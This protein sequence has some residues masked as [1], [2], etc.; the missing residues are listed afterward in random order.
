MA[1][2]ENIRREQQNQRE[3]MYL[4]DVVTHCRVWAREELETKKSGMNEHKLTYLSVCAYSNH[5]EGS[6]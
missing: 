6:D 3:S 1:T 5:V 4:E 2:D